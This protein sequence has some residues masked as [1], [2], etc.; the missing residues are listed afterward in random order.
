M[1][2]KT[3]QFIHRHRLPRYLNNNNN[4]ILQN[5][6]VAT[7][8]NCLQNVVIAGDNQSLK[9]GNVWKQWLDH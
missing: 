1:V 6:N 2:A 5:L 8:E 7:V 3:L 4:K 9:H